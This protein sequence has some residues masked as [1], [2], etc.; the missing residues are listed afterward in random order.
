MKNC[1]EYAVKT[2]VLQCHFCNYKDRACMSDETF[3]YMSN[4]EKVF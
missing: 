2:A 4:E 1:L 3:T